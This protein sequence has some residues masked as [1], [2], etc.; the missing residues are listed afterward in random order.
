VWANGFGV[1]GFVHVE[2]PR[3]HD[4][5]TLV[6]SGFSPVIVLRSSLLVLQVVSIATCS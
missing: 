4:Q 1:N 5:W 6:I 2:P 3:L